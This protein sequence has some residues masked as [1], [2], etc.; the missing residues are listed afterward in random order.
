MSK[1]PTTDEMLLAL[2]KRWDRGEKLTPEEGKALDEALV[3]NPQLR[4]MTRRI[5]LMRTVHCMHNGLALCRHHRDGFEWKDGHVWVGLSEWPP[6]IDPNDQ[7][8][9]ECSHQHEI[10]IRW[11]KMVSMATW[12]VKEDVD[13]MDASETAG[14][15]ESGKKLAG[16]LLE[17]VNLSCQLAFRD[18]IPTAETPTVNPNDKFG[19]GVVE[20]THNV[21]VAVQ[22]MTE[23]SFGKGPPVKSDG[24]D[25]VCPGRGCRWPGCEHNPERRGQ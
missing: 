12:M 22:T 11:D 23:L 17:V 20:R 10:R 15:A 8:C 18:T 13:K 21:S 2:W 9:P 19:P 5:N 6:H 16:L 4:K 14:L 7:L 25:H 24:W 3:N 1:M